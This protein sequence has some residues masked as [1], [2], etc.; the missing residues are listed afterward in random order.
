MEDWGI[1]T[2]AGQRCGLCSE[3][4]MP[5]SGLPARVASGKQKLGTC[6]TVAA[7]HNDAVRGRE[8]GASAS[9]RAAGEPTVPTFAYEAMNAAGQEVKDQIDAVSSE[10]AIAKIR[11]LG[12]F[13]TKIKQKGGVKPGARPAPAKK[14]AAAAASTSAACRRR[15]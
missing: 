1:I 10:D 15:S 4:A 3:M 8:T 12:Y 7:T 14:R 2:K 5:Y 6:R 11:T 13:P 9:R